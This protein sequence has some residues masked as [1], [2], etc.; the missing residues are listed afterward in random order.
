MT[1]TPHTS[2][3]PTAVTSL[4]VLPGWPLAAGA[5]PRIEGFFDGLAVMTGVP[6]DE[7]KR[8]SE[9]RPGATPLSTEGACVLDARRKVETSPGVGSAGASADTVTHTAGAPTFT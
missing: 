8:L 1:T 5:D 2:R 7:L 4:T 6:A 3:R 9:I